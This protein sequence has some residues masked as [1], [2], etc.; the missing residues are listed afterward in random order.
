MQVE[1]HSG[2]TIETDP[3]LFTQPVYETLYD[4]DGNEVQIEVEEGKQCKY[5]A[6]ELMELWK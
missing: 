5:T 2:K 1:Q 6:A 4:K 3:D